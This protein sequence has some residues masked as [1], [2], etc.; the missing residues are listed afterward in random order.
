MVAL[1][2]RESVEELGLEVG[3]EVTALVK[4]TDVV[5]LTDE[6]GVA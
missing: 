1:I 5:I 4:A 3:Q 6:G 2:T